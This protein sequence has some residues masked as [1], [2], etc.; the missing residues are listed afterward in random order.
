[1]IDAVQVWHRRPWQWMAALTTI[2]LLLSVTMSMLT[3]TDGNKFGHAIAPSST[4]QWVIS[5]TRHL[6]M[7][8]F[9]WTSLC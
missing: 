4:A 2:V 3:T 6:W 1:M 9:S 8:L 7:V 5:C